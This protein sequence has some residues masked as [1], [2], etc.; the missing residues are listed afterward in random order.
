V[1]VGFNNERP[2]VGEYA[3]GKIRQECEAV[4]SGV[5]AVI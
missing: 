1:L 2:K 3:L 5:L 4:V